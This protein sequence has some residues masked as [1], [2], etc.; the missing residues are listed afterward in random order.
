[1]IVRQP[2]LVL[3]IS[4][5]PGGT[6]AVLPVARRLAET[7]NVTYVA[8]GKAP[9]MLDAVGFPHITPD[10]ATRLFG[11]EKL[12][13]LIV[14]SMC[15]EVNWGHVAI[16]MFP[17]VPSAA[18]QDYPLGSMGHRQ[19]WGRIRPSRLLVNDETTKWMAANAWSDFPGNHIVV[20]GS[21][22]FD[23]LADF[24]I[25]LARQEAR[26]AWGISGDDRTPVVLFAGGGRPTGS[27]LLELVRCL[28]ELGQEVYLVV[29]PHPRMWTSPEFECERPHWHLATEE[30]SGRCITDTTADSNVAIAGADVVVACIS[31]ML[32]KAAS[33]HLPC[34]NVFRQREQVCYPEINQGCFAPVLQRCC[35][36]AVY[37]ERLL[38]L[39]EEA[40]DGRL[41]AQLRPAQETTYRLDGQNTARVVAVCERLLAGES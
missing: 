20:T 33:L 12:P 2:P 39:L 14:S 17:S 40:F 10:E 26:K 21:P 38:T 36:E 37:R 13:S 1:M 25:T 23:A 28:N 32:I 22:A 9:E 6:D 3:A 41:A 7:Y 11:G 15:S 29:R 27:T 16:A 4:A 35:A 8:T 5:D 31:T 24:D 34:I 30:L 19:P 18:I